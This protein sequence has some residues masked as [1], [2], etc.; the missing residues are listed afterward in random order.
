MKAIS[1]SLD[2][3]NLELPASKDG[4]GDLCVGLKGYVC[5]TDASVCTPR[6]CECED[7]TWLRCARVLLFTQHGLCQ[8]DPLL[9]YYLVIIIITTTTTSPTTAIATATVSPSSTTSPPATSTATATAASLAPGVWKILTKH[10]ICICRSTPPICIAV[11][12]FFCIA[13]LW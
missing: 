12:L 8:K 9:L 11:L 5:S 1:S 6:E 7:P 13:G 2:E 3:S 10:L 4:S